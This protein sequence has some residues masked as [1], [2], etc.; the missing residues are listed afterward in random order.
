MTDSVTYGI[1]ECFEKQ[2]RLP[3]WLAAVDFEITCTDLPFQAQLPW[4]LCPLGPTP[5]CQPSELLTGC[6]PAFYIRALL[7]GPRQERQER[8]TSAL[9]CLGSLC[10]ACTANIFMSRK[11]KRN[12]S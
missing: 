1:K 2:K 6:P 5:S 3:W 4:A 11:L 9:L 12:H 10:N 8:A 7:S